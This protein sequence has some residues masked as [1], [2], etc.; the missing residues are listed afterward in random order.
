MVVAIFAHIVKVVVLAAG[1]NAFLTVH[2]T[3]QLC[4]GIGLPDRAQEDGLELVHASIGEQEGGIVVGDDGRAGHN[5]VL[6]LL[7]VLEE[8]LPDLGG[9][10]L[11]LISHA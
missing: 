9:R 4:H 2:G 8:G 7:K 10:P 11:P 3:L 1:A 6:V 5:R